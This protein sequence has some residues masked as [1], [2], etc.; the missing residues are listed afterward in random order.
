MKKI[1]KLLEKNAESLS[2]FEQTVIREIE[3]KFL[4]AY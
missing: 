3:I 2:R 4:L 1:E